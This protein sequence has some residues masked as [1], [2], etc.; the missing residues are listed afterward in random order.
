MI[1]GVRPGPFRVQRIDEKGT[2]GLGVMMKLIR[3]VFPSTS[4]VS[5]KKTASGKK[6][7]S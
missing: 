3:M 7:C 4:G 2:C 1:A 5:L 6:K